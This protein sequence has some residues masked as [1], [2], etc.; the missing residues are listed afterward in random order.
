MACEVILDEIPEFLL[1][2]SS[3]SNDELNHSIITLAVEVL[4][5]G[6]DKV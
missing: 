3:R 5:L 2:S 6:S 1:V 4:I